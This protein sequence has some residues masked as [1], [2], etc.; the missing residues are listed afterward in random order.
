[1]VAPLSQSPA[2]KGLP[3][4]TATTRARPLVRK[5]T[6]ALTP[7]PRRTPLSAADQLWLQLPQMVI[8]AALVFDA[9]VTRA[10]VVDLVSTRVLSMTRFCRRLVQ[11]P[12]G[13]PYWEEVATPPESHVHTLNVSGSEGAA[14]LQA[15]VEELKAR[16]LDLSRAPWDMTLVMG[17]GQCSLLVTRIHHAISDGR[18][19]VEA[20]LQCD[21]TGQTIPDPPLPPAPMPSPGRRIK[22]GLAGFTTLCRLAFRRS[23]PRSCIKRSD[24]VSG[25]SVAWLP[26]AWPVSD[27]KAIAT[28]CGGGTV[29][30]VVL[31]V[32]SGAL[33]RYMQAKSDPVDK[34]RVRCLLP[35]NLAPPRASTPTETGNFVGGGLCPLPIHLDDAAARFKEVHTA[36]ETLKHSPEPAVG[37]RVMTLFNNAPPWMRHPM[38]RFAATKC[39][40]FLS[41]VRGPTQPMQLMG[42]TVENILWF[43][44]PLLNIGL[45]FPVIS[46]Q[47][48]LTLG[49][50][51]DPRLVPDVALLQRLLAEEYANLRAMI[52]PR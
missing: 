8:H 45:G 50:S 30:D 42:H 34:L 11:P 47:G 32:V 48:R 17:D 10:E 49:I 23:D 46:Y 44:P 7:T 15:A 36:M 18:G 52:A 13:K 12:R 2:P 39:T 33:R 26:E 1:M 21:E 14:M 27:V 51:A 43:V 37:A 24:A 29:N 31:T 25:V 40:V 5:T 20:I 3:R 22:E 9:P 4:S 41:N 38:H 28:A 16:P 35:F 19:L 6:A